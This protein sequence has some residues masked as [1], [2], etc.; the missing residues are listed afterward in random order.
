MSDTTGPMAERALI[1]HGLR[2]ATAVNTVPREAL[3]RPPLVVLPAAGHAWGDYH[4]VLDRFAAERRVAALD[5]PGFGASA[6]PSPAEFAYSAESYAD[7]LGPWL[8]GLGIARAV[9]L[10][11]SVG[12]AA[13]V[14]FAL[15]HP[16]RVAGL[17][18]VDPGGFT[19][20]GLLRT[21]ACRTLGTPGIL[22]RVEP[23]FT[24]F[25]LGPANPATRQIVAQH[26]AQ[27]RAPE[28]P[29][30]IAA[31]AALWRSFDTPAADLAPQAPAIRAPALVVRGALDPVVSAADVRR[32]TSALGEHGALEVVLLRAGHLPFL[33]QPGPFNSA[34]RGLL[35]TVE[36]A[37]AG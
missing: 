18:L 4:S 12:A 23:S 6:R 22:A 19:P 17:A 27:R 29:A 37:E 9:L 36:T 5:W 8:D 16:E 32:A 33:Q 11:N 14:C 1:V 2:L 31:Y 13:A 7:L 35:E 24:A 30:Y 3:S 26:R 10:G 28:Y 25:Y 21:L 20:S 34:V 15:T